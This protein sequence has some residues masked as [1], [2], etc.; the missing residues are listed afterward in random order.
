MNPQRPLK[1]ELRVPELIIKSLNTGRNFSLRIYATSNYYPIKKSLIYKTSRCPL[2]TRPLSI[3]GAT[4]TSPKIVD[5]KRKSE[6]AMSNKIGVKEGKRDTNHY[7]LM[8]A[9]D[10]TKET[11]ERYK[12]KEIALV[13]QNKQ[14][15]RE[16]F[17]LKQKLKIE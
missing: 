4:F 1:T 9:L 12:K 13:K 5:K 6:S 10:R 7:K 8:K 11:L 15:K 17:L 16:I 3:I 14:I 2:E